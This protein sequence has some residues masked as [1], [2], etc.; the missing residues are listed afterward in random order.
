MNR[1]DHSGF[2]AF[3]SRVIAAYGRR[4]AAAD[5]ED[6]TELLGLRAD[7]DLAIDRAVDG[8]RAHGVSWTRIA[9][10]AGIT[11]QAAQKRWGRQPK[12]DGRWSE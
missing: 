5:P 8:L 11:K 10:A 1:G 9:A 2:K 7:L 4:C 12:V 3:A 6:L